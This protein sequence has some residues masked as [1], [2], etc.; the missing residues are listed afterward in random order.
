MIIKI[1]YPYKDSPTTLEMKSK[2]I[3]TDDKS[4]IEQLKHTNNPV[5]IGIILS[6]N[7]DKYKIVPPTKED[8]LIEIEE[9][10]INPNLF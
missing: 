2:Y 5:E 8:L 6:Q 4:L 9:M 10:V 3:K 7:E 1:I